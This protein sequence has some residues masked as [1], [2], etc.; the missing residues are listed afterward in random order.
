LSRS[1][2]V[3]ARAQAAAAGAQL[4]HL[5]VRRRGGGVQIQVPAKGAGY[6]RSPSCNYRRRCVAQTSFCPAPTLAAAAAAVGTGDRTARH[7]TRRRSLPGCAGGLDLCVQV[8]PPPPPPPP[9]DIRGRGGSC[10]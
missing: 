6:A 1:Q 4:P 7:A 9:P 8:P 5:P 3:V 2:I 10:M